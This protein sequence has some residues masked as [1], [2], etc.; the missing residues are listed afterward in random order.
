[1][2]P[3]VAA[4]L[5]IWG[6]GASPGGCGHRRGRITSGAGSCQHLPE[7]SGVPGLYGSARGLPA[8]CLHHRQGLCSHMQQAGAPRHVPHGHHLTRPW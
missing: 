3:C 6:R 1:M 5:R 2:L 7:G 8:C 4:R